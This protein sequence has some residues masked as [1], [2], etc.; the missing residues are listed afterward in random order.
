MTRFWSVLQHVA[1]EGPG[2][3]AVEAEAR[4]LRMDARCLDR[5]ASIPRPEEVEGLVVMGG[6]MGALARTPAGCVDR[7]PWA[8]A[9]RY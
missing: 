1:W 5:G 3:V 9:R 2:L 8:G 4:G 7:P 6:P